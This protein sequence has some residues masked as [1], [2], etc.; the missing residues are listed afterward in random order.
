MK[1][2]V[3]GVGGVGGYFG[4][5]LA[6]VG[7]DVTFIA[8]G[9]HLE[10]IRTD[11][12]AVES[13]LGDFVVFPAKAT[14]DPAT[15]GP[16]DLVIFAVKTWQLEA[17]AEQARPLFSESCSHGGDPS[18]GTVRSSGT[19]RSPRG[20]DAPS[21]A[22]SEGTV[23]LP[24]LNG[25]ENADLLAERFGRERVLGGLCR[26]LSFIEAPGRIRHVGLDPSVVLGELD[27]RRTDRVERIHR[28]LVDAGIH[29]EIAPDIHVAIWR[30][31]LLIATWSGIGAVTRVPIGRWREVDGVRAMAEEGLREVV[32]VARAR[33]VDLS[34]EQVRTVMEGFDAAPADGTASMQRDVMAG[35]PS[36]LEAQSG[37]VV[38]LG[39]EAGVPTPVHAY[40]YHSLLPQERLARE[41]SET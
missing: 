28:T 38:R 6:A 19:I 31:F 18:S 25:V 16:V 2:A 33:G 5:R 9:E 29:T 15:V 41:E 21:S 8:R 37:A 27:N 22:S 35:R 34:A 24:L 26:I 10:A 23:A 13:V 3:V 39:S 4:G 32:A 7:H 14:D 40:L 12:L 11:G 20:G 36:E 1:I 30:K 17:A